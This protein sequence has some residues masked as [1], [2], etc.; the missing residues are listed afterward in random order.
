M[1]RAFV[2][3]ENKVQTIKTAEEVQAEIK[4]EYN[5][6]LSLEDQ[7]FPDPMTLLDGW[8]NEEAGVPLWPQIPMLYIIKILMLDNDAEDLS[9]YKYSKAYS[10]CQQSLLG[11]IFYNPLSQST[12]LCIIKSDCRPSERI[13]ETRH[14]LWILLS[15]SKSKFFSGSLLLY[16]WYGLFL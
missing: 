14:K 2:A 15:K 8:L 13:N 1:A 12:D 4:S 5:H 3:V 9:D 6:M 16:G 10:Y 7:S 11:E